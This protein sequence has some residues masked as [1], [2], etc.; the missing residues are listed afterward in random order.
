MTPYMVL[1]LHRCDIS[2]AGL[3]LCLLLGTMLLRRAYIKLESDFNRTYDEARAPPK[4]TQ[5]EAAPPS[6]L[7]SPPSLS[8]ITDDEKASALAGANS[9]SSGG[10]AET[11]P[12]VPPFSPPSGTALSRTP[13]TMSSN[14]Q[15]TQ[16]KRKVLPGL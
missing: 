13:T 10:G 2:M 6:P 9:P 1:V 4:R 14:K 15:P 3:W 8:L 12:L 7:T 16:K 11:A 5:T